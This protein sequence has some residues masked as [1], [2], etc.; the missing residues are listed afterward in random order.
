[1]RLHLL[2]AG[3]S[4]QLMLGDLQNDKSLLGANRLRML[5]GIQDEGLI[6]NFLRQH[7]AMKLAQVTLLAQWGRWARAWPNLQT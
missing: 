7:A 3:I 5:A 1:M 6:F 2:E 4:A